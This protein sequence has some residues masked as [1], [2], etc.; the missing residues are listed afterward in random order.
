MGEG[1]YTFPTE[2]QWEYAA[3]SF[4][5]KAFANGEISYTITDSNMDVMGWYENNSDSTPH[6]VA[7]KQTNAW[8]LFDMNGNVWE[9]CSDFYGTYPTGSVTNPLGSTSGVNR[10]TRGVSWNSYAQGC[11]SAQRYYESPDYRYFNIGLRL[12]KIKNH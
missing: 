9:W 1:S 10:V 3:R 11:R 2:A 8:G 7:Q 6:A 4:S 5:N 12:L